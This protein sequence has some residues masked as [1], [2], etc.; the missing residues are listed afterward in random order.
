MPNTVKAE[1]I[2][3]KSNEITMERK[4]EPLVLIEE[5]NDIVTITIEETSLKEKN[6]KICN[7]RKIVI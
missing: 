4:E 3:L 1:E 2:P 7:K 5:K 6:G